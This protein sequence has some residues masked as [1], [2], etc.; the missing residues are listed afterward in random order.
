MISIVV[1]YRNREIERVK[2]SLDSLLQQK[3]V[4]FEMIFIDY[5][6]D[7]SIS[8]DIEQLLASYTFTKYCYYDTRGWFWNRAHA[9]NTGAKMAKGDL[10]LFYD[11]DLILES[12]FLENLSIL[13]FNSTFYTFTCFYL[14]EKF[15]F[16]NDLLNKG[17]HY[18]QNYVGLCAIKRDIFLLIGGFDE[19]FMVWGVEDDDFYRRLELM[20]IKR[21]QLGQPNFYVFH[22]WH[23]TQSPSAPN[24]W[25]L[26]MVNYYYSKKINTV[27]DSILLPTNKERVYL[28]VD[29]DISVNYKNQLY[30][31]HE[32]IEQ[33]HNHQIKTLR[34]IYLY[35][36]SSTYFYFLMKNKEHKV[37]QEP[38]LNFLQYFIGVNRYLLLDYK[39]IFEQYK[40]EIILIKK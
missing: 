19:Y 13:T 12:N 28:N 3:Y 36:S 21:I 14:P 15:E 6:S 17:V 1:G 27:I 10:L 26:E 29:I 31:F 9:L 30:V 11:I 23:K 38:V 16:F 20:N 39:I 4:D 32:L 33:F 8:K 24:A 7:H 35:N 5:G 2:R 22:L 18:E 40:I 25:Y 37:D 34:Y